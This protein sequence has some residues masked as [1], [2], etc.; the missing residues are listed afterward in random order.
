VTQQ[1]VMDLYKYLLAQRPA[2]ADASAPAKANLTIDEMV[3]LFVGDTPAAA[4]AASSAPVPSAA[5]PAAQHVAPAATTVPAPAH[6]SAAPPQTS[7]ATTTTTAAAAAAPAAAAA[8]AGAP[9]AQSGEEKDETGHVTES[10]LSASLLRAVRRRG[11]SIAGLLPSL[12][13][14]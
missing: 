1:E 6:G 9:A 14:S 2:A 10:A 13:Q 5:A 8:S 4:S 3:K 12:S 11:S 7:T